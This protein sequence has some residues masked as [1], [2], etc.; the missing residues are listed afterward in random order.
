[1]ESNLNTLDPDKE[2]HILRSLVLEQFPKYIKKI[3]E[4]EKKL[5]NMDEL[6]L[7]LK[8]FADSNLVTSCN[9]CHKQE[10]DIVLME[11]CNCE[12]LFSGIVCRKNPDHDDIHDAFIGGITCCDAQQP[13]IVN[14]FHYF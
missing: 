7:T 8:V 5:E 10:L 6:I 4:L 14:R 3:E 2:R 9:K 12:K 13:I 11:C 1:M